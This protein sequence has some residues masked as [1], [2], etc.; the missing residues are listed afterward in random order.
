[1]S[2]SKA[3]SPK[4]EAPKSGLIMKN[5]T[6]GNN[7]KFG[8]TGSIKNVSATRKGGIVNNIPRKTQ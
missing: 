4:K 2:K 6:T 8:S 1:M 5:S 7:S 3:K